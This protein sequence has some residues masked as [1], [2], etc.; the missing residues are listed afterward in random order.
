MVLAQPLVISSEDSH[1]AYIIKG[2]RVLGDDIQL[3]P[4]RAE[5]STIN[6][7]TMCGA[8]HVRPSFVDS[9]MDHESSGVQQP[10]VPTINDF[11]LVVH[12][13]KITLLDEGERD[14]ERIDPERGWI[15]GIAECNMPS[16][17]LVEAISTYTP[18]QISWIGLFLI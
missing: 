8:Y 15:D 9:A 7:V 1:F 4:Q 5:C 10:H 14:T 18:D 3:P 16:N 6:T 2:T 11:P 17:A 13:D 12:L